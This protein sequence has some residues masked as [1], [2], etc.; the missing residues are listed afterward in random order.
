[1]E[2][3]TAA[4]RSDDALAE[5]RVNDLYESRIW[6]TLVRVAQVAVDAQ[7]G[8]RNNRVRI[9]HLVNDMYGASR[10]LFATTFR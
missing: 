4:L 5:R 2:R 3:W 10:R 7:T 1:M 6:R 8:V 9:K